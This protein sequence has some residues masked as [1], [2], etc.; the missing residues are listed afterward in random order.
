MGG[1]QRCGSTSYN[2][3]SSLS[4]KQSSGSNVNSAEVQVL[5]QLG[6][7][8]W[9]FQILWPTLTAFYYISSFSLSETEQVFVV[10][11]QHN[12]FFFFTVFFNWSI[13][14][15]QC[16]V[17]FCW[18]MKW[19]SYVWVLTCFSR[20]WLFVTPW[21][22]ALLA[23]LSMGSSKQEYWSRL[24]PLLHWQ[25]GSLP[26]ALPGISYMYTHIPSLLKLPPT[27]PL[28]VITWG[29]S[30]APCAIQYVPTSCLFNTW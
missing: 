22:A 12:L 28:L 10:C 23:Q 1:D 15:L 26:L 2:A 3:Q 29:P 24:Q 5:F 18:P 13:I 11:R 8:H 9:L 20:A 19:I 17:S 21:S 16:C 6:P 27:P 30:E 25:V 14:A 7:R 4:Q